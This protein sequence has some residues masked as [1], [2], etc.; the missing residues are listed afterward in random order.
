MNTTLGVAI[1]NNSLRIAMD[2]G[3][4][5]LW[6]EPDLSG[7]GVAW[8][9]FGAWDFANMKHRIGLEYKIVT[10]LPEPRD[11][12][13]SDMLAL[14]D[15]VADTSIDLWSVNY[16]RSRLIDFSYPRKFEG[17][18]IY[19]RA[20][21]DFSHA[22]LVMGVFD[23]ASF[24]FLI[25][26]VVA[27]ILT[28]WLLLKNEGMNCTLL[29][30]A[31]YIFEN[32][33]YKPLNS[34]ILPSSIPKRSIMTLF[35]IC[36]L[37]LNLMYMSKIISLLVTG[38]KPL[39]IDSL[40]DLEREEYEDVRIFIRKQG[41]VGSYLKSAQLLGDLEHRV[42]YFETADMYK[43]YIFESMQIGLHVFITNFANLYTM[44]CRSNRDENK[45]ISEL[46][47]FRQSRQGFK[48][49]SPYSLC[50]LYVLLITE[51]N[52]I[53]QERCISSEKVM[54]THQRLIMSSCGYM[55]LGSNL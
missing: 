40:A 32:V 8:H 51:I 5:N 11:N 24:R 44:I 1:L 41:A 12:L 26:A 48:P 10:E 7:S 46:E 17:I 14:M 6:L 13:Y 23:H 19:S 28:S 15:G 39:Q 21:K 20:R 29:T 52:C 31:L 53:Q 18:Y 34:S 55:H 49:I 42:D 43:P 27:M 9:G 30:C 4:F 45:T 54:N 25:I 22:D 16:K 2:C 47:D 3:A 38:S 37:A 35:T 33:M 36:N 50:T